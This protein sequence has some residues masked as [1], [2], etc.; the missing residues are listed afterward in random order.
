MAT[1]GDLERL[2][3]PVAGRPAFHDVR[4]VT[5]G[6]VEAQLLR[7]Q[8]VEQLAG[9]P[10]KRLPGQVLVPS[11]GLADQHEGSGGVP[12]REHDLCAPGG[13]GAGDAA[14]RHRL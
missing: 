2:R 13:K 11:R 7:E 1:G 10:D 8:P 12:R 6:A 4:D 3:V 14:A 5:A 9:P